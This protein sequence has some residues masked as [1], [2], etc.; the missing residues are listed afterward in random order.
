MELVRGEP[1]DQ[2]CEQNHLSLEERLKL[3]LQV[4][5]AVHHAHRKGIIHRDIKPSNVLV[6]LGEGEHIAKV[7][8]FGIAK[9]LDA[10]LTDSTLFT[11][12][13]QMVGTLEYM[14]PEQAQMS[15]VDIDTRSD[16]YS[17]GVLLYRLLT[18]STPIG[19][20]EL[21]KDGPFEIPRVI[22]ET[23][24]VR[25]STRVT[26]QRKHTA[27]TQPTNGSCRFETGRSRLDH[28]EMLGKRSPRTI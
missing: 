22:R 2:F 27:A 13:G 28:H 17:L 20:E 18:G 4:C 26:Q 7:I 6:G 15:V 5:K 19:K 16:V 12:F 21:L 24:P 1:I 8:D 11:E 10:R 25:P 14:S 9:A 23:T 3:F